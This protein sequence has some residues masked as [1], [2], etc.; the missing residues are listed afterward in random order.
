MKKNYKMQLKI[1][2]N[3]QLFIQKIKSKVTRV[4]SEFKYYKA[5]QLVCTAQSILNHKLRVSQLLTDLLRVK[6]IKI[7]FFEFQKW[8]RAKIVSFQKKTV[9]YLVANSLQAQEKIFLKEISLRVYNGKLLNRVWKLRDH[10]QVLVK[11]WS[12]S[13]KTPNNWQQAAIKIE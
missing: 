2:L 10:S 7:S 6:N 11:K 9:K 4:Q 12:R 1:R 3:T 5:M 8:F 13:T